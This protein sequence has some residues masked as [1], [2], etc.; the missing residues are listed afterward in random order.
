MSIFACFS[1]IKI[2]RAIKGGYTKRYTKQVWV[3]FCQHTKIVTSEKKHKPLFHDFRDA[4]YRLQA[5]C[6]P[7]Q[8]KHTFV[9]DKNFQLIVKVSV[10]LDFAYSHILFT[11]VVPKK[12]RKF[13]IIETNTPKINIKLLDIGLKQTKFVFKMC[14][15]WSY[16]R[17]QLCNHFYGYFTLLWQHTHKL[18]FLLISF[19][20][21]WLFFFFLRLRIYLFFAK[22]T[23]NE[24]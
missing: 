16:Q 8:T 1:F 9:T 5:K 14:N 4:N 11:V 15:V 23:V 24:M 12:T 3:Q 17:T 10:N 6:T 21:F 13:A 18:L 7:N 19:Q 22:Q 20:Q 2:R